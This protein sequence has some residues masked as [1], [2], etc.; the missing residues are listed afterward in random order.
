MDELKDQPQRRAKKATLFAMKV[1]S[2]WIAIFTIA[3]SVF[4]IYDKDF[5]PMN[6]IITSGLMIGAIYAPVYISMILD[7]FKELIL[8][9]KGKN[10]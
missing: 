1:A 7:K 5:L 2:L 6:E 3:R 9:L 8:A 10:D 4:L